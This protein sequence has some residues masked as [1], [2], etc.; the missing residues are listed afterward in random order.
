MSV[1]MKLELRL[2]C[3]FMAAHG[4]RKEHYLFWWANTNGWSP[5]GINCGHRTASEALRHFK[6]LTR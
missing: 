3:Q 2:E 5:C 6:E 4:Y 1:A